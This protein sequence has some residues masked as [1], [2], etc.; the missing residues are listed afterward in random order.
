MKIGILGAGSIAGTLASTMRQMEDVECYAVASGS[1]EKAERFAKEYGFKKA[2]GSYEKMLADQEVELIYIATPHSHHY[3]HMK[4]CIEAGKHVLCEKSFTVNE[5]QAEEVFRLAEEKGVLVTEAIWT[6]YMPSVKIINDLLADNVIGEVM[7]LTANLDYA[8]ADQERLIKPELAGGALLDVGVYPLNF[9][10]MHFGNK[11]AK[12]H[13]TAIMTETGVDGQNA[14]TLSYEDNR[15]AVLTSGMYGLSD[16]QGIF[17]GSK[18]WM[19]VDNVN[20][21]LEVKVYNQN[22]ELIQTVSM[23]KQINGYE[24]EIQEIIECIRKGEKECPSMKHKD[25][26]EVMRLMDGFRKEWGVHYPN[27]IESL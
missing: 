3:R 26:L 19:V 5:K 11:I 1:Q 21:P 25:T 12:T 17:Y 27:D 20:N 10:L 2:Y 18:G 9:A 13:S 24:Y 22:R 6:R 23:P 4:M 8:I 15:M 16:R 14:I 7:T